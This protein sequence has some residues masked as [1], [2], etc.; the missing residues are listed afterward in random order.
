MM[1]PAIL[2]DL[3]A[4]HVKDMIAMADKARQAQQTRRARRR[5]TSASRVA[6][7]ASHRL[8]TRMTVST[9][10]KD[11]PEKEMVVSKIDIGVNEDS[12]CNQGV[13][14]GTRSYC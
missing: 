9:K 13:A 11:R 12:V 4:E 2:R 5:R 1:H 3:A 10:A 7:T 14:S 6:R 8:L